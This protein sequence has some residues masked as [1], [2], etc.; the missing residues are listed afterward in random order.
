MWNVIEPGRT[1]ADEAGAIMA[2]IE[3]SIEKLWLRWLVVGGGLNIPEIVWGDVTNE[4]RP[5]KK[6]AADAKI[7]IG[8]TKR[9]G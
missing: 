4:W 9:K 5:R 2:R 8:R 1:E 7:D 3:G 6:T